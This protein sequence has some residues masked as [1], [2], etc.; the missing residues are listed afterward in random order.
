M[1]MAQAARPVF[2]SSFLPCRYRRNVTRAASTKPKPA[3]NSSAAPYSWKYVCGRILA[4]AGMW[5]KKTRTLLAALRRSESE[6]N[7][8]VTPFKRF[9]VTSFSAQCSHSTGPQ[10]RA[11]DVPIM[12][13]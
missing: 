1:E 6:R 12:G 3:T 13:S 9:T 10:S 4:L 8:T 5:T 11:P 2:G 7:V